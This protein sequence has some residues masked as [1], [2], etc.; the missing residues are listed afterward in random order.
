MAEMLPDARP[1][2][3]EGDF[4]IEGGRR[5]AHEIIERGRRPTAVVAANDLTA[6][7]AMQEFRAAGLK[8]P[9]DI[10]IIGFD[11]IAFASLTDPPLTTICLPRTELGRRA[12]E[13]LMTTIEHPDRQ[14]VE[15]QIPTYL[16]L[17][18]ST[19]PALPTPAGSSKK[20]KRAVGVAGKKTVAKGGRKKTKKRVA[21]N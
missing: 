2:I 9:H 19:A 1:V 21:A 5:A 3:Y 6:L 12:V 17:R 18:G 11:D 16:V 7:G 14:G 4:K 15:I 8:I 20:S 13:A 10:S